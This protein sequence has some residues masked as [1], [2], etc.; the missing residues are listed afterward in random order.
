MDDDEEFD[1]SDV[2]LMRYTV[3]HHEEDTDDIVIGLNPEGIDHHHS[4]QWNKMVNEKAVELE[5]QL[6]VEEN[7][8]QAQEKAKQEAIKH[9]EEVRQNDLEEKK[10]MA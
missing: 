2:V 10:R 5:Q 7:I 1:N 4:A 9:A 6:K 3:S 8:E